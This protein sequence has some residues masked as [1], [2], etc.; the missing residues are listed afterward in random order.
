MIGIKCNTLKH[1]T[2]IDSILKNKLPS[3][4][5][6]LFVVLIMTFSKASKK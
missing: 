2:V 6:D 1:K 4:L 3:A 5:L